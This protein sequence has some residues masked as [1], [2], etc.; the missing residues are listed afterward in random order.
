MNGMTNGT[1]IGKAL[2]VAAMLLF[3]GPAGRAQTS[4]LWGDS[5]ETWTSESRLPDF[6]F[7]GY[8]RGEEPYRIPA[9]KISVTDFGA[10]GDGRTDDTAAFKQAIAAGAGKLI[11]I[12]P[13]RFALSDLLEIR[14]SGTVLRG[15]GPEK[16]ILLFT[17]PGEVLKPRPAKTD[18]NE[19]TSGWSWGGGLITIAGARSSGGSAADVVRDER[20]GAR[21]LTLAKNAFKTGDEVL[22]T[23]SDDADKS[24]LKHLYRGKTG[25]ISGLNNWKCRQVFRLTAV[26]GDVVT[27]DRGLRFDVRAAWKPALAAFTPA[28]TDVGLEGVAFLFPASQYKGHFREVGYN[29]VEIGSSAAHCWLRDLTIW[30][31]DSG[32]Y[33][34]GTF[35]TVENIRFGADSARISAQGHTGHH[36]ITVGGLDCLCTGFDFQTQFIHDLTV[37]SAH[38]CVFCSGRA[39]NLNLD[40]H[41]WAPYE[42]LFT[43]IDAGDGRRLFASSG[44]GM[45]GLHCAAGGTFW[46]IRTREATAWP[47]GFADD[48]N[49][50]AVNVKSP[51]QRN[52]TGRWHEWIRPGEVQPPNLHRAMLEKRLGGKAGSGRGDPP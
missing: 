40:H 9:Q 32:P 44:G 20:R 5:G 10:R 35:C 33:V 51:A 18:G 30:N 21:S 27:L 3:A 49:I 26:S 24:L 23:V 1:D 41:R 2:L 25:D 37:Q 15:A 31:A 4:A 38:G 45:R 42:N 16:T 52:P 8:R 48:I 13:G 34:N 11:L 29:P 19:P 36:G 46:N 43:D 14:Q 39:V 50:V 17:K 47:N 28:L 22:L 7:A 6:S 12:P